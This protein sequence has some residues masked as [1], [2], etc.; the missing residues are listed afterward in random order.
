MLEAA[1]WRKHS[2]TLKIFLFQASKNGQS[3]VLVL[4]VLN[5]EAKMYLVS[6]FVKLVVLC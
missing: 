6:S 1:I 4:Q 2:A 3:V 5:A